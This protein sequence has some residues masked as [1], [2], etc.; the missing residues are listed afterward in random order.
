MPKQLLALGVLCYAGTTLAACSGAAAPSPTL[1]GTWQVTVHPLDVGTLTPS[2]F[3]AAI[4][5]SRDTYIVAMPTFVWSVGNVTYDTLSRMLTVG[6]DTSPGSTL[7]FE[8]WCKSLTCYIAFIGHMN[9]TRDTLTSGTVILFDTLHGG[10]GSVAT[11][12]IS[13]HK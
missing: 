5:S 6:N 11:A 7:A 9:Q 8:E 10:F 2:A 12:S 1:A 3:S 4:T 13:A